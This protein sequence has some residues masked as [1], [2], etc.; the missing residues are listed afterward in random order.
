M[1]VSFTFQTNRE[2]KF[3]H[4]EN[5]L[6]KA[7]AC[8][9]VIHKEQ[10]LPV[11]IAELK[12]D[13][14]Q[15]GGYIT[16]ESSLDI[17]RLDTYAW[18]RG[19]AFVLDFGRHMAGRFSIHID[20]T[21][22]PMDSPLYI[23]LRFAEI[24]AELAADPKDYN[25][26]LS[27]S[28]IQEEYIHLDELPA[29]LSMPRRYSFRFV[30]IR[31]MDTSPKWQAVFSSPSVSAET[32]ADY[33]ELR[34]LKL[35]DSQLQKIYDTGIRTLSECMQDVFEDG[36]KRDRRLWLGDLRLQAQAN[37]ASF[38]S[39]DLVKRCL[40][41]FAG[42]AAEDG[43]IPANVFTSPKYIPDD[44]FL[45]EYSL[46]FIS[47]LHDY[48]CAHPDTQLISDLYP[49]AKKQIDVILDMA[50]E[51]GK[52]I[53]DKN[54][55]VFIDWSDAYDKTTAAQAI[56]IYVLKQFLVLAE[57]YGEQEIP[58]YKQK[59]DLLVSY[60]EQKLYDPEKALFVTEGNE[61]NLASQVWMILAHVM[62][63]EENSRIMDAAIREFFPI[64][65]I[66]TPY[67]YH[68]VTEALFQS[69]HNSEAVSLM[70]SYWGKMIEL[71][72][73]TYWE[74]FD[75]DNPEF[76]PYGSAMVNSWCHAW[77]CTPVYLIRKYMTDQAAQ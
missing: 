75:P 10:I 59:L 41:L 37:Y 31:I 19:D 56:L 58:Y 30:E 63:S 50:D 5:L 23:R 34:L 44:T 52:L 68:H 76:S 21:G 4:D 28:W 33:T 6:G 15:M 14:S 9:P 47:V 16:V 62:S 40:Y 53:P 43:R 70:R 65:G 22:S 64:K 39:T 20:Q 71:G 18:K 7:E 45:F 69:S 66:V 77:S 73:D 32:S 2:L 12:K 67:M 8:K 48:H 11:C 42:M 46:F 26:W 51:E 35:E 61:Y 55:P 60:A 25:G 36:P 1:I 17:S 27:S 38:D 54:Y 24:P 57:A 3:R 13:T 49:S 74:A 72:A 29:V